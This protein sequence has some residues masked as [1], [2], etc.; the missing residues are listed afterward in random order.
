M[1]VPSR[2]GSTRWAARSTCKCCE[3]LAT[4]MPVSCASASTARS[5]W[6]STSRR[7]RRWGLASALEY[8]NRCGNSREKKFSSVLSEQ[9][10]FYRHREERGAFFWAKKNAILWKKVKIE[11]RAVLLSCIVAS[12][13]ANI[14]TS[15]STES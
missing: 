1:D 9:K 12:A 2:R 11:N 13:N 6:A 8:L 15:S 3:A 14:D 7:S 10:K 4:D 5:H